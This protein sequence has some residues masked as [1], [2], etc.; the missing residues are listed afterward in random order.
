MF[1]CLVPL[2]DKLINSLSYGSNSHSPLFAKK[3]KNHVPHN[4]Q[5]AFGGA[6]F[7]SAAFCY[8]GQDVF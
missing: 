2:S 4:P 8:V 3:K 5:T 1:H 6:F 7:P